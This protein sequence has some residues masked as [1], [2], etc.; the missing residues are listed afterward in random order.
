[1]A[2]STSSTSATPESEKTTQPAPQAPLDT[3]PAWKW[4]GS[5]LVFVLTTLI[6]GYD[7]SNVANIQSRI[8]EAFGNIKL[9]PWIG[10]SYSL[11]SFAVLGLSRKILYCFNMRWV[12]IVNVAI[13]MAGAA[14]AGAAQNISA[15]IVGRI[16]MGVAGAIVYQSNLTFVA[17]F[18][19]PA[20]SSRLFGLLSAVWAVG[21]VIGGPIGSALAAND[22]T[23]RRW[24]FY[25]NLPFVGLA[26]AIALLCIPDKYLGPDIPVTQR[27]TKIDPVGVTLNMG[28]PV[29][30]A[31]ALEFSGSTWSWDSGSTIA[32]WIIF[33]LVT[34]AWVVQQCLC[35]LTTPT[36]RSIPL[37]LIKRLDLL[38][39]WVASGC[40]GASYAV[41]LYYTPLFFSFARGHGALQQ[42]VRILPFIL[43][44]IVV[45][46]L[47]GGSL[48]IL[49]RYNIIYFIAG[50]A[51]ISGAA[52]MAANMSPTVSESQ[53][54]GLEALIGIGL[55]C[56]FQH[57]VGISNVMNKIPQDRV[58]SAILFNM[59][60]MGAIAIVLSIA[61]SIFQNVGYSLLSDALGGRGYSEE[62]I[63][64]ALAGVSSVVWQSRD[65]DVL[66]SG[67][68]A[69]SKVI[70]R[71]FY[72]VV[73]GGAI[74]LVCALAMKREKLDYGRGKK[75]K[76]GESA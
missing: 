55:G 59:A 41:T 22:H 56:S 6:N 7:V 10:L 24:A 16:I 9:L 2:E 58:D 72:L 71:E 13:F 49:G 29:L 47:V 43:V 34:I 25:M 8:Y 36:E 64:Q 57:G 68:E 53:V 26:L 73:A 4:K 1:M 31:V 20:D 18:A 15:V 52:A 38:P 14:V 35:I 74:C 60:Q 5:L 69:V 32:V 48:P 54:M 37:H 23:I 63:R 62:D 70:A 67:V 21:L 11:A 12:Y 39:L 75:E 44:F 51:T 27:L 46:I 66:N 28:S 19:P 40:A 45:V 61:G 65:R 50:A 33:G 76:E 17:V 42:T 30:F 3:I